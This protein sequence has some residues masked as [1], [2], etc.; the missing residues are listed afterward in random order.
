MTLVLGQ[1]FADG[2]IRGGA[3]L[4]IFHLRQVGLFQ[5][6]VYLKEMVDLAQHVR[7]Q[8][9]NVRVILVERII[10]VR[11]DDFDVLQTLI[12]HAQHADGTRLHHATRCHRF[13]GQHQNVQRI[14][15]LAVGLRDEPIIARIM[16]RAVEDAADLQEA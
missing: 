15:V 2:A 7:R 4:E 5:F 16:H 6:L 14:V 1:R 12:N 9:G 3:V 10:G 11:G 13:L 8:L